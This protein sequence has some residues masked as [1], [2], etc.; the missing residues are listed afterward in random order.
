MFALDTEEELGVK[1]GGCT[2]QERE[3]PIPEALCQFL[4][5]EMLGWPNFCA[6]FGV[7]AAGTPCC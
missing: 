1:S 6:E 4:W 2:A 5:G 3:N 7:G